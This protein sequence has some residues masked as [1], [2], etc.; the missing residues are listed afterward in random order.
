LRS[1]VDEGVLRP[2]QGRGWFVEPGPLSE[3][4]NALVSFSNMAAVLGL[5]ASARVLRAAVRP[6]TIDEAETLR[7]APGADL[8]VIERVRLLDGV[9]IALDESRIPLAIAPSLPEADWNSASLHDVLER[10]TAAPAWAE[11]A[12]IAEKADARSSRV[13]GIEVGEPLLV[14][15]QTTYDADDRPIEL[16]LMRYRGDRY[17]FRATLVRRR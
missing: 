3:P 5:V 9:A 1:L 10:H 2:S 16:G 6:A 14:A 15:H 4:P 11:F 8:F 7:V 13:L 12:V 17:R